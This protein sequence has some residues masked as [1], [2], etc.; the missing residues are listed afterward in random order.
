MRD[1]SATPAILLE[2]LGKRYGDVQAVENLSLSVGEGEIFAFLGRNGAGKTT[3]IRM[4]LGL[5]SPTEGSVTIRGVPMKRDRA[6][7]LSSVGFLVES[8]AAY[9]NLTVHENLDMQRRLTGAP[10]SAVEEV[11]VSQHLETYAAR[12]A[13]RLS[14]GNRQRLSIARALLGSPRIL[15]LDEPTNGLDPAGIVEMRQCLNALSREK[16]VTVFLSSHILGEVALM[17]DRIGI[18]H[19]GRLLE[20]IQGHGNG[21]AHRQGVRITVSDAARAAHVLRGSLGVRVEE[22]AGPGTLL[23]AGENARPE[24]VARAVVNAGLDLLRLS[25]YAEDLEARFLRLTGGE[26]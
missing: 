5:I 23:I 17:A 11:I 24:D 15:V 1:G 10:R 16:G 25:P 19:G 2:G 7:A 22:E 8:A 14:L 21:E 18:I 26:T 9:P 4:M 3:T 13:G 6:R 12:R 20:E